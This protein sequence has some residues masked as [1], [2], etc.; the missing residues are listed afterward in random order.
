MQAEEAN[1]DCR[2]ASH[3]TLWTFKWTLTAGA[4]QIHTH[5]LQIYMEI[6]SFTVVSWEYLGVQLLADDL[7]N[8]DLN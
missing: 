7:M 4:F 2:M 3:K 5:T 1:V 6:K 8:L